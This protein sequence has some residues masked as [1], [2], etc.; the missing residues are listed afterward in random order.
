MIRLNTKINQTIFVAVNCHHGGTA[1]ATVAESSHPCPHHGRH[2]RPSRCHPSH[3]PS[4]IVPNQNNPTKNITHTNSFMCAYR[5]K[6]VA[7]FLHFWSGSR[8]FLAAPAKW[9]ASG[10][11]SADT[12]SFFQN[13]RAPTHRHDN[14]Y[15]FK[16]TLIELNGLPLAGVKAVIY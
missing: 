11:K 8:W 7:W 10:A 6:E 14:Y 13:Q 9:R 5:C 2:H 12:I 16:T 15:W 1:T 3:C 4:S